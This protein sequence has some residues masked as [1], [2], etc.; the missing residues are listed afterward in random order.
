MGAATMYI[1]TQEPSGGESARAFSA[2]DEAYGTEEFTVEEADKVLAENGFS[3][4][5]FDSLVANGFV[6][7]ADG[8]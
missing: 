1:L 2:L 8:E 5:M 7:E 4:S 3:Q 6:T